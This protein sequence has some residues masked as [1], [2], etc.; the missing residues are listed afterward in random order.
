[1]KNF[2]KKWIRPSKAMVQ[3]MLA[4]VIMVA[5]LATAIPA[6]A[7]TPS[8]PGLDAGA[9]GLTRDGT[10][11]L[12]ADGAIVEDITYHPPM[13]PDDE[14]L[15]QW[16]QHYENAPQAPMAALDVVPQGSLSLLSHLD[17]VPAQRDQASCGNCWAWAGTGAMGIALDVEEGIHD[18]L[19]VQYINSC[20]TAV[21][22]KT[23]CSGGWLEDVADFYSAPGYQQAIP[24]SNT[25]AHWQ[26]GDESCDTK[27]GSIS[28]SPN[29]PINSIQEVTIPTQGVGQAKAIANIKS[30]LN[31]NEA[32]W[33]AFFVATDADWSAFSNFWNTQPES[34]IWD[35][36]YSCG[37]SESYV[38]EVAGHAV[39]ITG[40][41]DDDPSHRYWEVVNSWGTAPGRPNGLFRLDMNMNYDCNWQTYEGSW[42]SSCY[43]QKLDVDF[44][45]HIPSCPSLYFWNGNHY[46]DNGFILGGAIP[47]EN[48]YVHLSGLKG[49]LV[50]KDNRYWLQ[51]R[52]TEPEMSFIDDAKLMVVHRSGDTIS[53]RI[54]LAPVTAEHSQIGDVRLELRYSD[55][56]YV[57][58]LPGDV[59]TLSF[60][61]Y[62]LW[63]QEWELVFV[64]EGYYVA[65]EGITRAVG[66]TN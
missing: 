14:T 40:Y 37:H 50:A 12:P 44:D 19:S 65:L 22:G 11:L 46:I 6:M 41:N 24:W 26:D 45:I 58:M 61:Y 13:H 34:T 7:E 36:D 30:A 8:S 33:F 4:A 3:L 1:M 47:R 15:K 17:Y 27:C 52:E 56:R 16:V 21:I 25:N 28:T 39:L 57:S 10:D 5:L 60:P 2:S 59:I 29:Y 20:E 63:N 32:V 53:K 18:R 66:C 51:I 48:E 55:D 42:V 35:F 43:F 38:D 23:C 31:N 49:E 9:D 64:A 62:P 54:V